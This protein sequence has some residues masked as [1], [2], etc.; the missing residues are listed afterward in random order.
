MNERRRR[1]EEEMS[2]RGGKEIRKKRGRGEGGKE[3]KG[4]D[5][6]PI[7]LIPSTINPKVNVLLQFLKSKRRWCR[8]LGSQVCLLRRVS[9]RER[10]GGRGKESEREG[11]DVMLKMRK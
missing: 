6:K 8:T 4:G 2:D 5:P 7:S 10:E 11:K 1:G 9:R 3:G